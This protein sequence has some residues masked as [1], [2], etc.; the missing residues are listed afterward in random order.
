MS[1]KFG[2]VWILYPEVLKFGIYP[3]K[4]G[5]FEFYILTFF[6]AHF[7][8]L[9]KAQQTQGLELQ[10]NWKKK[11]KEKRRHMNGLRVHEMG[12]EEANGL[13]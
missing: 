8:L 11:Q 5:I 3:L 2:D 9:K 1:L 12:L 10:T 7:F 6:E 4:F 13:E